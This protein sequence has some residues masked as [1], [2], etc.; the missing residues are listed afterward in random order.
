M[1]LCLS[2][3]Q[4]SRHLLPIPL[5]FAKADAQRWRL[6]K[7]AAIRFE[8]ILPTRSE[9]CANH[10]QHHLGETYMESNKIVPRKEPTGMLAYII[11]ARE[12]RTTDVNR[13][14]LLLYYA[15]NV[16]THGSF[17]KSLLD[18]SLDTGLSESTVQRINKDWQ[19][20]GLLSWEKG[21]VTRSLANTYRLDLSKLQKAVESTRRNFEGAEQRRRRKAADRAKRYRERHAKLTVTQ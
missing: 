15:S 7:A 18:I 6:S 8:H 3:T 11:A 10:T 1:H 21:S 19:G 4:A 12:I 20:Q 13:K 16:N 9:F 17:F 14:V 5:L 2:T